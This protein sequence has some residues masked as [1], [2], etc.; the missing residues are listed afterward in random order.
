MD[1]R[2]SEIKKENYLIELIKRKKEFILLINSNNN[3]NPKNI[4]IKAEEKNK[5]DINAILFINSEVILKEN[6]I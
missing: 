5:K 2:F 3:I 1:I 6:Y 4:I